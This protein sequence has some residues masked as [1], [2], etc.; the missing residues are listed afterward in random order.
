MFNALSTETG[1]ANAV[2]NPANYTLVYTS[3]GG[4]QT[5]AGA[6]V[7]VTVP[8]DLNE[9]STSLSPLG[10]GYAGESG[11]LGPVAVRDPDLLGPILGH[12][13]AAVTPR[14]ASAIWVSGS[15][16]RALVPLLQAGFRLESF[17]VLLCWDRPYAD[18]SRYL[19]ISP[20]LL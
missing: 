13:T 2:S 19:P 16:D 18:F 9:G 11:R 14:G 6:I 8:F 10:Y 4:K 7:N 1:W 5:L 15:A 17:P 12:L 3:A 20:G